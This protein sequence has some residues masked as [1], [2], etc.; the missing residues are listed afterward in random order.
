MDSYLLVSPNCKD[1]AEPNFEMKQFPDGE[2]YVWVPQAEELKGKNV[3]LLHRLYPNQH[4]NIFR[5]FQLLK[6]MNG[7]GAKLTAVAPYFPYARQ[8]E[9]VRQGEALSAQMLCRMMANAGLE[10]LITFDCHFISGPGET[11]FESL[12]IENRTMAPELLSYVKPKLRDP[13]LV[14]TGGG[15]A[16]MVKEE[17]GLSLRKVH[18]DYVI[19][20][21]AF[22]RET[23]EKLNFDV[24]GKDVMIIDDLISSGS[25][26]AAAA[27][28]C[29]AGGARRIVC[30][31]VHGLLVGNAFDRIRAAG[32]GE[33]V[34]TD[35]VPGLASVVSIAPKLKDILGQ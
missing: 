6:V 9:T 14:S 30:A 12:R 24:S 27:R 32:A 15:S 34:V 5:L 11:E 7:I 18:G 21:A 23:A 26:M 8:D 4:T 33:V 17:G 28:A 3:I 35:T 1:L 22:R 2:N 19:E 10:K 13:L 16:Y 29:K 25:T 31:A 20:E